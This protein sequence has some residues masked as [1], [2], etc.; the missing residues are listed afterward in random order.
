MP[1]FHVP[2]PS[3]GIRPG[4]PHPLTNPPAA[5]TFRPAND[6]AAYHPRGASE[7]ESFK[8]PQTGKGR[9]A[10]RLQKNQ[11]TSAEG[12]GRGE[13]QGSRPCPRAPE[14]RASAQE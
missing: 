11:G 5:H 6:L 1:S 3:S 10:L 2:P 12:E 9:G 4:T 7:Q 14:G 13:A 8:S